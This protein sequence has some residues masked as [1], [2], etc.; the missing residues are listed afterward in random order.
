M[1]PASTPTTVSF[2]WTDAEHDILATET[3]KQLALEAQDKSFV[4]PWAKHWQRVSSS[5]QE[6]GYN[7][8][9]SACAGY[10]KRTIDAQKAD[11]EAA[12]PKWG[13]SEHEIL[14]S[15][16]EDQIASET[17]NPAAILTWPQH[18]KQ[19]SLR[20]KERG[21]TR[22]VDMC[23]AYWRMVE[24]NSQLVA[25][26]S[27][28]SEAQSIED[29]AE[30]ESETNGE[31]ETPRKSSK[32]QHWTNSEHDNL[33]RLLKARR[34]FEE[35]H[36]E[37]ELSG[38]KLW[39]LIARQHQQNGYNRTWEACK[40]HWHAYE[41]PQSRSKERTMW[42]SRAS[43]SVDESHQSNISST[44]SP[45]ND[46]EDEPLVVEEPTST[47]CA[48]AAAPSQILRSN[49]YA[50]YSDPLTD[51]AKEAVLSDSDSSEIIYARSKDMRGRDFIGLLYLL[52]LGQEK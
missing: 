15:M 13:D 30:I 19:V 42:P 27:A 31:K 50:S 38:A 36:D 46:L 18:W 3:N 16:T 11:E 34:D 12:G 39:V 21:Y 5:L 43:M 24:T 28:R 32:V 49:T 45:A 22:S 7:R 10:W 40:R 35:R 17:A 23:A 1:C 37:D 44:W 9:P 26:G 48:E 51:S 20:L 4:I 52:T 41:R 25:R 33:A 29:Q 6:N 8:T 14:L 2:R 47:D